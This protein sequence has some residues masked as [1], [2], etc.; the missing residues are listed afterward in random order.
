MS[1]PKQVRQKSQSNKLPF[2]ARRHCVS[3][4]FFI[5]MLQTT[6]LYLG[7]IS[8]NVPCCIQHSQN[9]AQHWEIWNVENNIPIYLNIGLQ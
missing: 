6:F 8:G 5:F 9:Q 4:R 7:A 2:P 1:E 3:G